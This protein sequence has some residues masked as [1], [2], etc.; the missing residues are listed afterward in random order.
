MILT[1][2]DLTI[3]YKARRRPATVIAE[4]LNLSLA[5]GELICLLGPN[6]A[7]K[8]TLMRTIAG[9]QPALGGEILLDGQ[10]VGDYRPNALARKLSVVLTERVDAGL[11]SAYALVAL[12]R[13]PYT[14]WRGT[15]DDED[16]RIIRDA[17]RSVGA[18]P[19]ATRPVGE[20]SDGERQKVMI[21]RA[22]AQQPQL[23]LL[24]EPTAYLDLPRRAEV[25]QILRRL[26][27]DG[28]RAVLLSTHDLDLALRSADKLW[29]LANGE[30]HVGAPEDLVLDG[31][32]ARAF[33]SEGVSFDAQSGAFRVQ[34]PERAQIDVIGDGLEAEWTRRAL[35]RRGFSVSF[36]RNGS[37]I[38]IEASATGWQLQ[39]STFRSEHGSIESLLHELNAR[40]EAKR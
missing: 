33:A 22:L 34:R 29:L 2:R 18:V 23:M 1:T 26:A 17:M 38:Q 10:A 4:K 5:A 8:S 14:D 6:G 39:T 21:A 28:G 40:A 31:T 15:L 25:M 36:G 35:E 24:D 16:E 32:F 37:P 20:L 13:Y 12:G 7:G 3:G 11:L 9:M 27:H 19:L 30:L